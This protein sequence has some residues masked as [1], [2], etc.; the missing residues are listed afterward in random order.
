MAM[1]ARVS[2]TDTAKPN[3]SFY[4]DSSCMAPTTRS[5]STAA[6]IP[7]NSAP[8]AGRARGSTP[9]YASGKWPGT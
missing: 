7:S 3:E 5:M 6:T 9:A 2:T 1:G 4:Y 8:P